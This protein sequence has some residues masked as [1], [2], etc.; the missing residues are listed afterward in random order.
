MNLKSC[1]AVNHLLFVISAWSTIR[2]TTLSL[3]LH[4]TWLSKLM[5]LGTKLYN[6][7]AGIRVLML[8]ITQP[9]IWRYIRFGYYCQYDV[10]SAW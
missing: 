5:N 8:L 4:R 1:K 7:V 2:Q 6:A 3:Q 9:A 10:A